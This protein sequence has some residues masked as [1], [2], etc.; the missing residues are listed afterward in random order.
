MHGILW[1]TGSHRGVQ[2]HSPSILVIT[3][4]AFEVFLSDGHVFAFASCVAFALSSP[5][6]A[7]RVKSHFAG[8]TD[9]DDKAAQLVGHLN[10]TQD[11]VSAML[12]VSS[13]VFACGLQA[14]RSYAGMQQTNVAN[15]LHASRVCQTCDLR[16]L[17]S[18]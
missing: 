1:K 16:I 4:G 5:A 13:E 7:Q 6:A 3:Y 18:C 8:A 15:P 9:N 17:P 12:E 2:K 10:R 11:R 14:I